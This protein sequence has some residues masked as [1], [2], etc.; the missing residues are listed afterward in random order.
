[1]EA[2]LS[3][4][5]TGIKSFFARFLNFRFETKN[6]EAKLPIGVTGANNYPHFHVEF[7]A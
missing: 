7:E 4:A 3:Q 5:I 6:A 2:K 1:M